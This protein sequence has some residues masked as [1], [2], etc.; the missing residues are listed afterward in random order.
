MLIYFV[1]HGQSLG[2]L[3]KRYQ[4]GQTPLSAEG[5][6]QAGKLAERLKDIKIDEIWTSP[7]RRAHHT[8]EIINEY[9]Q[10]PLTVV[11]DLHEIKRASVLYGQLFAAPEVADLKQFNWEENFDD[12]SF[13]YQDAESYTEVV[14]RA[15][16]VRL[17][18]Q[19]LSEKKPADFTLLITTHGDFL[20]T[21]LFTVL[22]GS[23]AD[24]KVII[25]PMRSLFLEN[26][27]LSLVKVE[28]GKWLV[29]AIGDF[30]HL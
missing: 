30:A 9:Q 3:E 5:E 13:K 12:P 6:V 19:Q 26:T 23:E 18:L 24:P 14:N 20:R 25:Q 4:D 28:N 17:Q 15:K 22:F 10:A 2:N 21:F 16:K 11:Q 29:M 8:A 1:R 27:A 7:Y